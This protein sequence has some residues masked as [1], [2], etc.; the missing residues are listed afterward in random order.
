MLVWVICL[1]LMLA[2]KFKQNYYTTLSEQFLNPMEQSWRQR[3]N[4]YF[5]Q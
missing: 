2:S 4:C 1:Y 5:L 3:Q